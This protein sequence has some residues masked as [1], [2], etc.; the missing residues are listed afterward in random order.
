MA[1][2]QFLTFL[3]QQINND[4]ILSLFHTVFFHE[5][6]T[7]TMYVNHTVFVGILAPFYRK[8]AVAMGVDELYT[9]MYT[10]LVTQ[11]LADYVAYLK[12]LSYTYHDNI[13]LDQ[14]QLLQLI[15]EILKH[16][17]IVSTEKYTDEQKKDFIIEIVHDLFGIQHTIDVKKVIV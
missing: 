10:E 9:D 4:K 5:T 13:A 8:E 11:S 15:I 17:H 7:G 1:L 2:A 6:K 12:K 16:F 14:Q 3:L